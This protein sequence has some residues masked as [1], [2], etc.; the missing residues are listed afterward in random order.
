MGEKSISV[1]ELSIEMPDSARQIHRYI[2]LTE[3]IEPLLD[4]VDENKIAFRPAVELSYLGK[5]EQEQLLDAMQYEDCTPSLAQATKIKQFSQENKLSEAVILSI[6]QEEKPNQVE[7]IKI[8]K[9]RISKFFPKGTPEKKIEETIVKALELYQ[10]R[11][12]QKQSA[13]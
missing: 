5:D 11:E 12:R 7:K 2:R 10:K 6:L 8:P 4:L 9:E 1:N 3:L 13:R